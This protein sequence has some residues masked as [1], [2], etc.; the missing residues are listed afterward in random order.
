MSKQAPAAEP[1]ADKHNKPKLEPILNPEL[2]NDLT[3][4]TGATGDLLAASGDGSVA[5]QA[6]RLN[7]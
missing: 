7:D 2:A 1:Q 5:A 4:S 6:A 3:G